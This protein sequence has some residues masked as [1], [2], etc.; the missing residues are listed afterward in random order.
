VEVCE[1]V[2]LPVICGTPTLTA[3]VPSAL[4]PTETFASAPVALAVV[5]GFRLKI[6]EHHS[7]SL[8]AVARIFFARDSFFNG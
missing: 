2:V 5:S 1:P 8:A 3:Y 4:T 6:S 7:K